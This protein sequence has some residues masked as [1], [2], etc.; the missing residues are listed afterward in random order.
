[1]LL[2]SFPDKDFVIKFPIDITWFIHFASTQKGF[3]YTDKLVLVIYPPKDKDS[4]NNCVSS[5]IGAPFFLFYT[6][7]A[8]YL[9]EFMH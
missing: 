8:L 3:G 4:S 7:L 1:M 9:S 2:I 5:T 6:A